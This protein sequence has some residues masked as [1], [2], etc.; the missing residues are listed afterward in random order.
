[1]NTRL[2]RS[3]DDRM[4]AGVAGGLAELW[5]ADPSLVRIGWALLAVFTGGI[6]LVV[7]IVMA[8]VVPEEDDVMP[9]STEPGL[10]PTGEAS[11][12]GAPSALAAPVP[13]ATSAAELARARAVARQARREERALRRA[14]RGDRPRTGAIVI[15][16][17]FILG[18][19]W[20]LVREYIPW[21]DW[22]W[23][24]PA[25]LVGIG[26]LVLFLAL[27]RNGRTPPAANPG[28]RS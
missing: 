5:D 22:D 28:A 20:F 25:T 12:A 16:V 21:F 4:I 27:E 24:W 26:I 23:V 7:Y 15:G 2:F 11:L 19:A 10:P 13:P 9:W 18:G 1:M 3:R 6:A 8:I 17:L 14:A